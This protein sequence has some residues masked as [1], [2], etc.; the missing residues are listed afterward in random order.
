VFKGLGNLASLMRNAG[1]IGGK[2]QEISEKLKNERVTGQSGGG[3]IQCEANGLGQVLSIK[4]EQSL[5]AENEHEMIQDLLPAAINQA[6]AKSKRLH[7]DAMKSA[8]GGIDIPG[9]DD[10]INQFSGVDE[11]EPKSE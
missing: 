9:L 6:I 11:K 4:I 10:A 1:N 3:M 2:M 5:V 8:T 7:M